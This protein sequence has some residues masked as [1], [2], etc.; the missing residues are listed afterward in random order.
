MT[1]NW[2]AV[3]LAG[4][5]AFVLGGLWYTTW[6]TKPWQKLIGMKGETTS[7]NTPNLGKLLVGSLVLELIMATNLAAFIGPDASWAFGL[8]AGVAAGFGWVALAFGVN[9]MFEGKP[10]KL[11][12]I[13][14]GYN[15]VTFAVMGLII[16]A[17]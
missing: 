16:G 9:Y 17:M 12:L 13:N 8:G 1:I 3:L 10:F 7:A 5:S 14:A 11:W 15:T 4:L 6:F 2:L